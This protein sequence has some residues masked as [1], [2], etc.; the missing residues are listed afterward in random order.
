MIRFIAILVFRKGSPEFRF[1]QHV[2]I[3]LF[4][5]SLAVQFAGEAE[6]CDG[7]RYVGWCWDAVEILRVYSQ[8]LR[9]TDIKLLGYFRP[10][11]QC[12]VAGVQPLAIAL[13]LA[14]DI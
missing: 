6:R 2:L 8:F 5:E 4:P 13:C 11:F 1:R 9:L 7:N 3:W 10:F 14:L 12:A